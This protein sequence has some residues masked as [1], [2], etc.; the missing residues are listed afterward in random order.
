MR[1][2]TLDRWALPSLTWAFCTM[3]QPLPLLCRQVNALER[4]ALPVIGRLAELPRTGTWGEWIAVL[5]E[6]TETTLRAPERVVELLAELEPIARLVQT[7][8]K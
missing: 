8:P 2:E 6:L 1:L 4:F 5:T 7:T 3:I